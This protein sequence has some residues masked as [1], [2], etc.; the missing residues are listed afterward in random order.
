MNKTK[1]AT[2]A[3][4]G[5]VAIAASFVTA[6][7]NIEALPNPE[8]NITEGIRFDVNDVQETSE[9]SLPKTHAASVYATRTIDLQGE[10]S[11][12]FYIDE[13]TIEGVNPMQI[14]PA[15]RGSI[16]TAVDANFS[17]FAAKPGEQP[18]YLYNAQVGSN[19][20]MATPKEWKVSEASALSFYAICPA[21]ATGLS[22][23][24]N[25]ATTPTKPVITYSPAVNA[26]N[27]VDL[28][29]AANE[30]LTFN[31]Y[32]AD[33]KITLP[34]THATTA[35]IFQIGKDLS[36]NRKVE[37]IELIGVYGKGKFNLT[38][39]KWEADGYS[40]PTT[41]TLDYG[42]TGTSTANVEGTV[43]NPNDGTF[44]MLPQT[45]PSTAKIK[46]TFNGGKTWTASIAGKEWVQ[47]TT[48][49]YKISNT[50]DTE[51]RDFEIIATPAQRELTYTQTTAEFSIR[52]FRK[53]KGYPEA[54]TSR[55]KAEP[56]EVV[57]YNLDGGNNWTTPSS[58]GNVKTATAP[59]FDGGTNGV[60]LTVTVDPDIIDLLAKRN[61]ELKE[62]QK[63]SGRRDLSDVNGVK[64]AANCYIVSAPGE[65]QIPIIYGN[66]WDNGA[67]NQQAYKPSGVTGDNALKIFQSG[68]GNIDQPYITQ[69]DKVEVIWESKTGLVTAEGVTANSGKNRFIKFKV[70]ENNIEEGNAI[71][72][73]K[74]GNTIYWSWHIWITGKEVANVSSGKFMLEPLG[75]KH[76][77]WFKTAY[78]VDR[79]IYIKLRQTRAD[80]KGAFTIIKV[81]QK[82]G[83]K[84][85][86]TAMFYQ[87]GRKDPLL[88]DKTKFGT[89]ANGYS[90]KEAAQNPITWAGQCN[91][92][93]GASTTTQGMYDWNTDH[94]N[95]N[96]YYNLWDAK[97]TI[98]N[99]YTDP[100]I[101]TVYDP[102]PAGF[103]VPRRA[104][105]SI[106]QDGKY[107]GKP[108][109]P[110]SG[111]Y[112]PG[113]ATDPK[114][115]VTGYDVFLNVTNGYIWTCEKLKWVYYT[116]SAHRGMAA[117]TNGN[118]VA[119]LPDTYPLD[120][121]F[122]ANV[123]PVKE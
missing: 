66:A 123:I 92:G 25:T 9:A 67:Q 96:S 61:K 3:M 6:C 94:K 28:L 46:I 81:I 122:G 82:P 108:F 57:G 29:V 98:G 41:F 87:F 33:N 69:G 88:G 68:W 13:S 37:K 74:N 11:E 23:T 105:F 106:I 62:A 48:K 50:N 112:K 65:Y 84:E 93:I 99:S 8:E 64:R 59:N 53:P 4:L 79:T 95:D 75:L 32:E 44:L 110:T 19:G 86:G 109:L 77:T 36:Y 35:I 83:S 15:T 22:I 16:K 34:F 71:I 107:A 63:P 80:G 78:D 49:T 26:K 85:T 113:V 119:L 121:H 89:K 54:N 7:S 72:A 115:N 103:H 45:L 97:N 51:D 17:V 18:A 12:G 76:E 24:P 58:N 55:D 56:W 60:K 104:A 70:D 116:E 52:S 47:G 114:S 14:T 30:N 118:H 117:Y 73:L 40:T 21:T 102:S 43:L 91:K 120:L 42:T 2:Y 100:F 5:I 111:Y 38:E 20:V 39:Q 101:K 31:K 1:K 10:G 27:Q 90:L